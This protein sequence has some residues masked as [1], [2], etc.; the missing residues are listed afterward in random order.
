MTDLMAS[1]P[2]PG[3]T[4]TIAPPTDPGVYHEDRLVV[5]TVSGVSTSQ[6]FRVYGATFD[7][8]S[9]T[10]SYVG[11]T[12]A[13]ATV[14]NPNGSIHYFTYSGTNGWPTSA[15]QGSDN[16]TIYNAVDFG[17]TAGGSASVNTGAL[18]AL[19]TG[20]V[21]ATAS[22]GLG[23]GVA[24]IPQYNFPVNATP[25]GLPVP[26]DA[27]GG[28][29]CIIEGLGTGGQ[30]TP[31]MAFH[32]S[33]NDPLVAG[34][35]I[36][37]NCSGAHTSGG[38]YFRNLAFNWNGPGYFN[39]VCLSLHLWNALADSCTFTNTPCA[40]Y[41]Q[42]LAS[43]LRNCTIDYGEGLHTTFSTTA[44]WLSG[45][46]CEISGPSEM[47]GKNL[48]TT[49]T[50]ISIGGG[51]PNCNLNVLRNLH[52]YQWS[53][54]ID[55]SDI[56]NTGISSGTQQNL[57]DGCDVDVQNTAILLRPNTAGGMFGM[58]FD[59]KFTNNIFT[60][61]QNSTNGEPIV[62]IDSNGG[63]ATNID[64]ISLIDNTIYS[65]VTSNELYSGEAQTNQYG[66]QIGTWGAVSIVGGRISQCGRP[67]AAMVRRTSAFRATPPR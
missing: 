31:N 28:G 21:N 12:A 41:I 14:Q 58:I 25:T 11:A 62:L 63:T 16:N 3:A 8:L 55:Y 66:V 47:L 60:K 46:N 50:C 61:G 18:I 7:S 53:Y 33:I 9:G 22:A 30:S 57:I 1:G 10:W 13:Y 36:F 38:T 39:D 23:G 40:A 51:P 45:I 34:P 44:I 59:Q 6:M 27:S 65:N 48:N 19:F 49:G 15:W 67:W 56:N 26:P 5:T 29:G 24:R 35:F 52:I 64:Q 42:G 32:F 4:Y 37:L 54:G 17:A 20:M 43:G 2:N